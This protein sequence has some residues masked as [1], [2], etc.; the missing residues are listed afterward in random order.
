MVSTFHDMEKV[1]RFHFRAHIFEKIERTERITRSLH[2]EDGRLQSAQNFI[3]KFCPVAH[4]AERIAKTNDRIHLFLQRD[5]ASDAS[6]HALANENGRNTWWLSRRS[7]RL[8]M[9]RDQLRQRIGPFPIFPHVIVIEDRHTPDACQ[10]R[11][12]GL[13]PRVRRSRSRTGS[14][15]EKGLGHLRLQI[16]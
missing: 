12:P 9:R 3:A 11:F 16:E 10:P 14:K 6:A 4:G 7:E 2:K 15:K 8:S 5:M 13:H 1:R